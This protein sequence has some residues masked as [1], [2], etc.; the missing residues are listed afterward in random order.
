M[1]KS[2]EPRIATTSEMRMP[3]QIFGRMERLQNEGERIF[4]RHGTP[5]P[6]LTT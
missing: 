5:P 6:L 1:T 2:S 3:T 4:R